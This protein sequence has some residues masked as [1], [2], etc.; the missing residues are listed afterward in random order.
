MRG[1]VEDRLRRTYRGGINQ[2]G[3][4]A[5]ECAELL[6]HPALGEPL[7]ATPLG[8]PLLSFLSHTGLFVVPPSFELAEQP[9]TGQF[10]FG[11]LE[12]LI[13]IV[14]EDP[15]FHLAVVTALLE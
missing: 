3:A 14:I 7:L 8:F 11:D 12:S 13:N 6:V 2:V 10:L 9:F 1:G 5:T 15:N 4:G